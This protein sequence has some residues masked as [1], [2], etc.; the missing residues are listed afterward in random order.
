MIC[1]LFS[2]I[3]GSHSISVESGG[4]NGRSDLGQVISDKIGLVRVE[5]GNGNK[6]LLN[7]QISIL[8]EIKVKNQPINGESLLGDQNVGQI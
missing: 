7:S 4:K 5:S 8:K 1:I 3:A 6:N 2:K